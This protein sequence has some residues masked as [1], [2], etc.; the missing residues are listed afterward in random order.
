MSDYHI[1]SPN[2]VEIDAQTT[3]NFNSPV[4]FG[5]NDDATL[6]DLKN[7]DRT[8][9]TTD[10]I[11]Q[12]NGTNFVTNTVAGLQGPPGETGERGETGLTGDPGMD[13][14][15]I[16]GLPGE[17]GPHG[18]KGDTGD[19][20]ADG[21]PGPPGIVYNVSDIIT[22]STTISTTYNVYRVDTNDV[23]I[24]IT[25]PAA[26]SDPI[27][28]VIVDVVGTAQVH[29]ITVST[30]MTDNIN[31]SSNY[32]INTN[33]QSVTLLSALGMWMVI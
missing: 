11:L 30:A 12:W 26:T 31:G 21:A 3:I 22:N 19:T 7:I 15:G 13:G 33:Y 10:D 1:K 28:F 16:D 25:L 29:N 6:A 9:I 32:V 4:L 18:E 2:A 14:F 17:I 27:L 5:H 20:G 8:A 24:T 23:P